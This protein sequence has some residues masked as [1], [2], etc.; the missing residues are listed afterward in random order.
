MDLCTT[1]T[2][3][4][5]SGKRTAP[6]PLIGDDA[7]VT[8]L[9]SRIKAVSNRNCTVVIC[10]ES[11]TGKEL[12][13]RHVHAASSRASGPFVVADCTTLHDTLFESQLFGHVK[14]AFT[15]A[16]HSTLGLF[17]SADGGTLFLDEVAELRPDLQ[18]KLLRCVEETA[19]V[20]LG[21]VEQVPVDLRIIA[22]TH[23]DLE[24]MVRRGAFRED[25]YYRLH[26]VRLAVPPL[27]DR[28]GDIVPLA[29]HLLAQQAELY[30][31][32]VK[33]LSACA[34]AAL[35][36]YSWPG[37]V[38]ELRNVTEQ[39]FVLS[40]GDH[41]TAADLPEAV[42]A[43]ARNQRSNGRGGNGRRRGNRRIVP[44]AVVERC[45]IERALRASNGN[46][47]RAAELL[48]VER[49]RL[50]RMVRRH[51]LQAFARSRAS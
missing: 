36:A 17:R 47:T 40:Q 33:T 12:V 23:R 19:V 28:R 11:G 15:G 31:E 3:G 5:A 25:L 20:P 50:S 2:E 8:E 4:R 22:A 46:Q 13:A 39:A 41:L 10:G 26:V 43:A 21:A 34:K 9:R 45:M 29:E 44:L 16:G 27:R 42:R 38:R 1:E 51:N 14:G 24:E 49:H 32:P 30:Q 18:S 48:G 6:P 35:E 37:N 7:C